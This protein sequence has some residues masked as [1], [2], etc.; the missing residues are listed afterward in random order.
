MICLTSRLPRVR[1]LLHLDDGDVSYGNCS[2]DS[3]LCKVFET[4]QK[5]LL[6]AATKSLNRK[7]YYAALSSLYLH[8]AP[9]HSIWVLQYFFRTLLLLSEGVGSCTFFVQTP[10]GSA[11]ALFLYK[12]LGVRLLHFFVQTP[13]FCTNPIDCKTHFIHYYRKFLTKLPSFRTLSRIISKL[14]F[15]PIPVQI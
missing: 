11:P 2:A 4:L 10:R 15:Q 14:L 3:K 13:L 1:I 5:S 6:S 12:R 8:S 7:R 9:S